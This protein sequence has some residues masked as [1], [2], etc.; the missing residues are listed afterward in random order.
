MQ[1]LELQDRLCALEA[2]TTQ[3]LRTL[4]KAKLLDGEQVDLLLDTVEELMTGRAGA[5]FAA[6]QLAEA[7]NTGPVIWEEPADAHVRSAFR[8]MLYADGARHDA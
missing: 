5:A 1:I 3:L 7:A 2:L 8:H 4:R 6:Q